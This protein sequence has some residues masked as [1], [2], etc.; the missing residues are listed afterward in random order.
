MLVRTSRALL[1]QLKVTVRHK[2]SQK[3]MDATTWL[4]N[5]KAQVKLEGF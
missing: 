3:Q 4:I 2:E 1:W 5:K